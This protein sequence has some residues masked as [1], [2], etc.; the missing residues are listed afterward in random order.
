MTNL[1]S[2]TKPA[3][4]PIA[5]ALQ[6]LGVDVRATL[7]LRHMRRYLTQYREF[8]RL[9]GQ[10]GARHPI[11]TDYDE[12]AGAAAGHYF[13]QDLLV[14]SAIHHHAPSRHIDIG[15]RLDGFVAHVA[16]F[17]RIEVMDVRHLQDTGHPNIAFLRADL[18][19]PASASHA[20]TDS[21]SC[22]HAIEHFGLGR[23][24]DPLDPAGHL[25]GF[26]NMVRMVA[27]GG[28]FYI[29]FPVGRET[30]VH[31]NAHRVF[32]PEEILSWPGSEQLNLV[33]FDLVDDKGKLRRRANWA[34]A[35][36]LR[37][38]CGIYTFEKRT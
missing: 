30:I 34:D 32:H 29:S 36:A 11:L 26:R 13:H 33:R 12:Q 37:Y 1:L 24:G 3:L 2:K 35:V 20:C 25:K 17:R 16:S 14:A 15:S 23:Y 5:A 8:R 38:G 21:L 10:I 18:M 9:G 28:R 19:D 6:Y 31:F 27:P 4:R 7:S 22:L